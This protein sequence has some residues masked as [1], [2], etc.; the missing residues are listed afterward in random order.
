VGDGWRFLLNRLREHL[1]VRPLVIT[2]L[3]VAALFLAGTVDR[4]SLPWL[5]DV[6]AESVDTLLSIMASSMLVIATF[7]VSSM[8]SAYA[9]AGSSATPRSFPLILADDTSQ[10]ALSAFVGAFI[11]SILALI[12]SKNGYFQQTGRL[13]LF[14]LTLLTFTIVILTFV[15]WVDRI[16]RLGRLG[17]TIDKVEEAAARSLRRRRAAPRLGGVTPRADDDRGRAVHGSVGYVQRVD[18]ARLQALAEERGLRIT[19]VALP[20]TFATPD[21]ALAH[22]AVDRGEPPDDALEPIAA[23]FVI[24]GERAFDEDPR[25]GLVV[26][27][28]IASRALSPAV[29]DGGTAIDVIGSLVRLFLCWREPVEEEEQHRRVSYDRVAVPELQLADLFDDAFVA[30]ARD[31]AAIVEV[32]A[33]LQKAFAALAASGDDGLAAAAATHSKKALARAENAMQ[34]PDDLEVLRRL[35]QSVG[36]PD[37]AT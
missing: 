13:V 28:E 2:L 23:A 19:V 20:G 7:A 14:V 1:W 25:F 5:P 4:V 6:S 33:R 10:N 8:V 18:V 32:G 11:F 27:A 16:A 34:L 3:S 15:R 29:N 30:I 24:G 31:G 12:A 35:A 26:L 9:S 21:R 37:R 36:R 22:V 17:N